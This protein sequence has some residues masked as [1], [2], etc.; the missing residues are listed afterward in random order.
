LKTTNGSD[1]AYRSC[2]IQGKDNLSVNLTFTG[3]AIYYQSPLFDGLSLRFTLDGSSSGDINISTPR[4]SAPSSTPAVATYIWQQLGLQN[5]THV[6]EI[7]PGAGVKTLNIGS[8]IITQ[9]L[10]VNVTSLTPKAASQAGPTQSETTTRVGIG[11]GAG[12]GALAFIIFLW[13][14]WTLAQRRVEKK[15]YYDD[16]RQD[17]RIIPDDREIEF[18]RTAFSHNSHSQ[19]SP[20]NPPLRDSGVVLHSVQAKYTSQ[21]TFSVDGRYRAPTTSDHGVVSSVPSNTL[22]LSQR[23]ESSQGH[24]EFVVP[25]ST[26]SIY[27]TRLEPVRASP[28]SSLAPS[29][30]SY[31]SANRYTNPHAYDPQNRPIPLLARTPAAVTVTR[32]TTM[33][34]PAAVSLPLNATP[35]VMTRGSTFSGK[36]EPV[37]KQRT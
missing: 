6:L 20:H 21:N 3:V 24:D 13:I 2:T 4:T 16:W 10:P 22:L 17:H 34:A 28:H 1:L 33:P 25:A 8:F 18:D 26:H 11:F 32:S 30:S 23:A 9:S 12:F 27:P 37:R 7:T 19:V 31:T 35:S 36:L 29:P 5:N 14:S 15:K